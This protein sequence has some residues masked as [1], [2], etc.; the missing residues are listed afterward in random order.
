MA[1]RLAEL[2]HLDAGRR[3]QGAESHGYRLAPTVDPDLLQA[4]ETALSARLPEDYR[5]FLTDLGNGGAGPYF[6]IASLDESIERSFLTLGEEW[7]D[8]CR[9]AEVVAGLPAFTRDFPLT[10]DVDFGELL[11]RPAGWDE[12]LERL[13][14][15]SGYEARW[16]ELRGTYL[17]EPYDGGWLPICDFG[18]GDFFVLVVRGQR[19]GTVWANSVWSATGF[20]CLEVSFEVFYRRW[21]DDSLRRIHAGDFA[22]VNACYSFL[23]FGNNPRYRLV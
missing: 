19:R 17:A 9:L 5:S 23:R 21:L 2:R 15:D 16:E 22:P 20:Y 7:T 6:G 3:V 18:C 1:E 8:E 4:V 14:S 12:H 11:E 13:E 10:G